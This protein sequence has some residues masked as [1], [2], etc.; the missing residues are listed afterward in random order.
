MRKLTL[1][2]FAL[3][4]VLAS[5]SALAD[6]TA[7]TNQ[8]TARMS[9]TFLL[10]D[11]RV[12]AN[13]VDASGFSTVRWWTLTPDNLGSY[14][15]GTW[16]RVGDARWTHLYFGSGVFAD[17]RVMICGGEYST[18]GSETNKT[19]IFNPITNTW[20]EIS[21]PT[22]WANVG[23]APSAI[24]QD[25]RFFVGDI[26]SPRTAFFDPVS[27]TWA[28]GPNT[29]NSRTTEETWVVLPDNSVLKWDCFGHPGTERWL[30][31]TNTWISCGNTPVDLVLPGSFETGSGILLPN[32]KLFAIGGTPRT[33]LYT[34]PNVITQPGT[35]TQGP[36]PPN[37]NG[38]TIGAEDAP[39]ALLPN[40]NVLMALGPVTAN[41]GTFSTPTYY[42]EYDG[43]TLIQVPNAPNNQGPPY[44]S[45]FLNLPTGEILETAGVAT[46]YLYTNGGGPQAAWKPVV[47][48]FPSAVERGSSYKLFGMQLN[49]VSNGNGYG[50]EAYTA[51]N[52]PVV[53]LNGTGGTM[54][55]CRTFNHSTMGVQTGSNIVNTNVE[56]LSTVP[57]DCYN[58]LV[59]ACGMTSD[60]VSVMV[61]NGVA[62]SAFSLFR[63]VLNGGGLTELGSSDD[64]YLSVGKGITVNAGEAP[65]QVIVDGTAGSLN[66]CGLA[67]K[68]ESQV[69]SG[70]LGQFV[71]FFNWN[72]NQYD[73]IANYNATA[74]DSV[75]TSTTTTT[76]SNY[77][78]QSTGQIRAKVSIK[79]IG[80]T[81]INQWQARFD[82]I[83]WIVG[84]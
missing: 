61:G 7:L 30:P 21:G 2:T 20:T 36:N 73:A 65:I 63:G 16:A 45:H 51:I 62:V 12:L 22:G 19:E 76:P 9:T 34:M 47:T 32:G 84:G 66:P 8:P 14:R 81:T 18:G 46:C 55:R 24:L 13:E 38:S 78:N 27:N 1:L 79:P 40:G 5:Q 72:T 29:L 31:T 58:V 23:D 75:T 80:L 42:F 82:Q 53:R 41:G 3:G 69:N 50:D 59:S 48:S 15:N 77:V 33:C 54:V 4:T 10:T 64:A 28:A 25:G 67:L 35:W 43:T 44:V 57:I 6:W 60:P 52:Y 39:A 11:G 74:A 56:V 71:E 26:F 83:R 68:V 17:G 37:V 49:G 70:G